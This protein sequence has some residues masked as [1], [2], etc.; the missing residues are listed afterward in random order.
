MD[1]LAARFRTS[2]RYRHAIAHTHHRLGEVLCESR[3]PQEAE[4]SYRRA[5]AIWSDLVAEFPVVEEYSQWLALCHGN[6]AELFSVCPEPNYRN[7]AEAVKHAMR[8]VELRPDI[9]QGWNALGIAHYRTG[10]WTAA[11]TA[12]EKSVELGKG[13]Y[14]FDWFFLAMAHSQLGHKE[15]ASKWY[16]QAAAWQEKEKDELTRNKAMAA[17]YRRYHT[18]AAEVLGLSVKQD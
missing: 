12:L 17:Q 18:E 4:R 14:W 7:A 11:I 5:V 1:Q 13:G 8:A 9:R 16:D 6:M 10:D 3:R 15:E 2:P